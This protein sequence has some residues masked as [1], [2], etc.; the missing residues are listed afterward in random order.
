MNRLRREDIVQLADMQADP[1][2]SFYMPLTPELDQQDK[3]RIQLKNML[4]AA[5]TQLVAEYGFRTAEADAFLK[6]VQQL[7]AHGRF[8][9]EPGSGGMAIFLTANEQTIY[10]LPVSFEQRMVVSDRFYLKPLLSLFA[11]NGR[12]YILAL[13][14]G[15]VQL[16]EGTQLGVREVPLGDDVPQNLDEAMQYDDPEERLQWHTNTSSKTERP[17]A[18]HGHG[19][20]NE[21][22]KKE[23][24]LRFFQQID[25][26]LKAILPDEEH[27]PLVLVGVDYLLPIYRNANSY[28]RLLD[29]AI[30]ADPQ[31]F[32]AEELHQRVW[33]EIMEPSFA[34]NQDA[35][36]ASFQDL[37][38]TERASA[39][40]QEV[41]QA[42]FNGQIDVLFAAQDLEQWGL[43][44]KKKNKVATH[45]KAKSGDYDL[46][47]LAAVQTLMHRG[48]VYVVDREDVPQQQPVAAIFRYPL[49]A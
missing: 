1:S 36:V 22:M 3:N 41:V 12:F 42:A 37:A 26:G 23:N 6:P 25:A 19:V 48:T 8:W 18:F 15:Q 43:F 11:K 34:Q 21:E 9:G 45:E 29:E 20:T 5:H 46:V 38:Q 35:A 2:I 7:I 30:T 32:T 31:S 47:D 10:Y 13:S 28:G 14:L 40:L 16:L 39:D 27:I 17:A 49:A 33:E 24:A 44:D 4:T